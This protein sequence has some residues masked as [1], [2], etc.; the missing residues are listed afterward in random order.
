MLILLELPL[1][2]VGLEEE[3]RRIEHVCFFDLDEQ[4]PISLSLSPLDHLLESGTYYISKT[5]DLAKRVEDRINDDRQRAE[6]CQ[7]RSRTDSS[8]ATPP[9]PHHFGLPRYVWNSH[10]LQPLFD[11]R[12]SLNDHEKAWF[13]SRSFA[14]PIIEGFYEQKRVNL[15]N[16]DRVTLTVVSRHGRDR[17]GTRFEK[18]GIDSSGNVRISR[19]PSTL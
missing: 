7:P 12:E 5:L 8:S 13:D 1:E 17:D 9:C 2:S 14:L 10:L 3:V 16:G 11:L 4:R 6:A 19:L 18:R 15:A